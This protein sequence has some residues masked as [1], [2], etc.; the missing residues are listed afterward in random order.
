MLSRP[1]LAPRYVLWRA[2]LQYA[3]HNMQYEILQYAILQYAI[4]KYVPPDMYVL[5]RDF[6]QYCRLVSS[7][8]NPSVA[9]TQRK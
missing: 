5:W 1:G 2:F 9:I 4:L 6:L 8:N 7:L 3:I